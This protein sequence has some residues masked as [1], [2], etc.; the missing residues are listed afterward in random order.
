[1]PVY[2]PPKVTAG[3]VRGFRIGQFVLSDG[4][5]PEG[6]KV[7]IERNG[8]EGG[9]FSARDLETLLSNFFRENY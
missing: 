3:M 1:M 4:M 2:D 5:S 7:Y 8:S 6:D 9:D